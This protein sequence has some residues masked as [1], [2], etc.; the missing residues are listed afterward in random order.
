MTQYGS[1]QNT[2]KAKLSAQVKPKFIVTE[3]AIHSIFVRWLK[4]NN[5][6][7]Y[8][9]PNGG[10]R[11]HLEAAKLKRMGVVAGIPDITIPEA[12]KGYHACY[13][14]L[15]SEKGRL[16]DAQSMIKQQLEDRGN[17]VGVAYSIDEAITL[18]KWYLDMK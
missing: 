14:E 2:K 5:I 18:T 4:L 16:S 12:R 6:F 3:E 15:K 10:Y 13:I 11:R 1:G 7:A 17:F 8:H 9:C